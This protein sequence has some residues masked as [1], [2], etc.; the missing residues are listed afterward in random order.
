MSGD[1]DALPGCQVA[2][3]GLAFLIEVLPSCFQQWILRGA[4]FSKFGNTAFEF[5][6]VEFEIKGLDGHGDYGKRVWRIGGKGSLG[7]SE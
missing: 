2:V 5:G 6:K 7:L 4:L 1:L 3:E